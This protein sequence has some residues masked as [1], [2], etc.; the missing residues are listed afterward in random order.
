MALNREQRPA[1]TAVMRKALSDAS[2]SLKK[3]IVPPVAPPPEVEIP[4]PLQNEQPQEADTVP[5]ASLYFTR[6]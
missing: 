5:L 6:L 2:Q 4:P 3:A 1:T